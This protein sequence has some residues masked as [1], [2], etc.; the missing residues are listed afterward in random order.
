M[1][2]GKQINLC[3]ELGPEGIINLA[4]SWGLEGRA[5]SAHPC[6][7]TIPLD[8]LHVDEASTIEDSKATFQQPACDLLKGKM[9]W[10]TDTGWLI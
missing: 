9:W 3:E 6:V 2:S 7:K 1:D 10:P 5:S 4:L 8:L